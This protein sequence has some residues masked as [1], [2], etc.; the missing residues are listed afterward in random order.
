MRLAIVGSTQLNGPKSRAIVLDAIKRYAP[1]CIVS[2]GAKGIDSL[3]ADI[4]RELG[5]EVDEKKPDWQ[6][7]EDSPGCTRHSEEAHLREEEY[8]KYPGEEGY[9]LMCSGRPKK[10]FKSRNLEI[11]QSCDALIRIALKGATTYGSGWTRD[12]AKERGVPT[13]EFVLSKEEDR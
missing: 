7:W 1:T 6:R 2:G 13:E 11:A 9:E 8:R 5:L 12:R 4:G 10:G 3:A